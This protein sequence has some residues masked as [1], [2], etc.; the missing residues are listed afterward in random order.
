VVAGALLGAIG[1][2]LLFLRYMTQ[3][4]AAYDNTNLFAYNPLWLLVLPGLVI[5]R[6]QV[7]V[8]RVVFVLATMAG[9][10]TAFGLVAPFLPG[11]R[12]GS[13]AVIAFATP[14]G[15]A[16]AWVIRERCR[17]DPVPTA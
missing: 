12:Q 11:F 8:R 9:V 5:A 6:R 15:I 16:A 1:A 13:F 3:H 7:K 2:V 17:P 14:I 4:V 10:L